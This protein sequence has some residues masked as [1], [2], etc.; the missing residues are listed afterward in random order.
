[1]KPSRGVVPGI[2]AATLATLSSFE[3]DDSS[4]GSL[5]YLAAIR[6]I[7]FFSSAQVQY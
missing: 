5:L 1:M 7:F 2:A 3:N 4:N 6:F